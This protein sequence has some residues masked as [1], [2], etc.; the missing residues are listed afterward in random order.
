MAVAN[1]QQTLLMYKSEE[2]T[3]TY[4]MTL[5]MADR[6]MAT[7]KTASLATET[8]AQK[9]PYEA[10]AASNTTYANS[11]Q[12]QA[13]LENIENSYEIKL[14]EINSWETELQQQQNNIET[15]VK[16]LQQYE[17]NCTS[18]IKSNI[19]GDFTYGG[20]SGS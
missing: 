13:D 15:Q 16:E 14:S 17:E 1:L 2:A 11:T 10:K 3:L 20:S 18:E 7:K 19:K 12:Y 9:Q 8:L 6:T 5:I 4:K